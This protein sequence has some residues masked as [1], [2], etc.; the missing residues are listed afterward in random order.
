MQQMPA[1]LSNAQV[2]Q[3]SQTPSFQIPQQQMM[4][5]RA[6]RAPPQRVP[7]V[8][9]KQPA[10]FNDD[11]ELLP[12]LVKEKVKETKPYDLENNLLM[13]IKAKQKT[14]QLN[15][16]D[17]QLLPVVINI[18]TKEL[19]EEQEGDRSPIDLVCVIDISGSMAGD[20]IDLVRQTLTSLLEVLN[21]RD[22]LCLVQFDDRAER[23]TP[24][25]RNSK[26][27]LEVFMSMINS[28]DSRG[29]TSIHT[30]MDLAF[31]VFKERRASNPVS[32]VFLLTDG[33]DGGADKRVSQKLIEHKLLETNFTIN[34]FGF[35][36]DHDEDLLNNISKLK[37]GGFYF[38]DKLDTV[39]EC[40]ASALGGL[41]SVV[42]LDVEIFVT[43]ASYKPFEGI[44]IKKTF[45]GM[46]NQKGVTSG[47]QISLAQLMAGSEKGYMLEMEI[48]PM[49]FKVED[50]ER[51]QNV[52][53]VHL[54]AKDKTGKSVIKKE[55]K[56]IL[57]MINQD[58]KMG[59]IEEDGE[60]MENYFRVK[61][62]E[63][64]EEAVNLANRGQYEDGSKKL[65]FI[66]E[67]I[68]QNK[69]VDQKKMKPMM[70]QLVQSKQSC[71]PEIY[72]A[73]GKKQMVS[74]T[75]CFMEQKPQ[76]SSAMYSNSV[77]TKMVNKMKAKKMQMPIEDIEI[78]E[79]K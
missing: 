76:A 38:I 22:R 71:R 57:H 46:W 3:M 13:E 16:K 31:R 56:L 29:G 43:N 19:D 68:S 47:Y 24:L 75:K 50:K 48:P 39:D 63:A 41:M 44:K 23:L 40:F 74:N 32:S 8:Q 18:K 69:R 2:A 42:A 5:N 35:G 61:G 20:K 27:N 17:V 10:V 15:A 36:R 70:E 9:V 28:L 21:E 72:H 64:I 37:D 67:Q 51:S 26:K 54:V 58:E 34:C 52:L 45:G 12:E 66:M 25:L 14:I 30:G 78:E 7:A 77:Q 55:A 49:S 59:D 6:P 1:Q 4:M 73:V 79:E 60:V 33:L 65:D 62:A 11:E 53:D